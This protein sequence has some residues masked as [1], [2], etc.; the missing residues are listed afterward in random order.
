M[1][2]QRIEKAIAGEIYARPLVYRNLEELCDR[3]GPR[4]AGSRAYA[5]AADWARERLQEYGLVDV[6]KECVEHLG[7]ERGE[8]AVQVLV[9]YRSDFPALALPYSPTGEVEADLTDLYAAA[10]E[11]YIN[12]K[13]EIKG[14]VVLTSG[15]DP[16][17]YPRR[18]HRTEKYARAVEAGAAGF[19]FAS[20]SAGQL[21]PTGT[22]THGRA[23]KIIGVG[24]SA[25]VASTL[26]RW[27]AKGSVR[28]K[29]TVSG[30]GLRP[31]HSHNVV[32]ELP[33]GAT[34]GPGIVLCAHLD[35]H[36]IAPGADDNGSGVVSV[37]EAARA[38][39]ATG[40]EF[41]GRVRVI[42]F[43]AEEI[44]LLGATAYVNAHKDALESIRMVLNADVTR[45]PRKLSLVLQSCPEVIALIEGYMRTIDCEAEITDRL[46]PYSDH[47][48]FAL[49]GIPSAMIASEGHPRIP[50]YGHTTGDTLDKVL[51]TRLQRTAMTLARLAVRIAHESEWPVSRRRPT[52]VREMLVREGLEESLRLYGRWPF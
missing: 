44:G 1:D 34:D 36:D 38:L 27:Q 6:H 32:A 17:A 24:I 49:A 33:G 25:E 2:I 23:G 30:G 39:V 40:A 29:L 21:A 22:L 50:G 35:S 8:A 45:T 26:R 31:V 51:A 18:V 28:L 11:A 20:A 19:L 4:F 48:P 12:R 42:L 15:A 52:Q 14:K 5:E 43:A 16:P 46:V 10:P 41:P 3:F 7:W 13:D 37:M 9:P 47:F